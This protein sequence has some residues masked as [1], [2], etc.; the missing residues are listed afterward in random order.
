MSEEN[1]SFP[2]YAG[3]IKMEVTDEV[4]TPFGG[5]VAFA[6]FL[7]KTNILE[8]LSGHCPVARTSP[9]AA[10]IYDILVSFILTS[11]CDGDR[12]NHVN[13][14]R[15][16][17]S[18]PA[19][20][21]VQKIVGDDTIRRFFNS[22][23]R[24]KG[25]SWFA[26]NT[27]KMWSCLPKNFILDW[28]ST[29][30]TKYGSQ[31][32]AEI[33]YNPTKRGRPSFHPLLATVAGTRIVPYYL[34]RPGNTVSASQWQDAMEQCLEWLGENNRPALNRGD[35]GFGIESIMS[36]HETSLNAPK[37]LFKLKITN[38]VKA[39]IK[40]VTEEEWLGA[41]SRGLLQVVDKEIM[42]SG[43]TK[44]RRVILSRREH[45]TVTAE[46]G[47]SL[48]DFTEFKYSAYVTDLNFEEAQAWQVVDLYNQRGDC[49]NIFDELKNQWGLDGFCSR[50]ANVTELA[51]RFTLLSY[52]LWNLFSRL[53]DPD[54]HV[55]AGTGRRWYML[56]ASR[57]VKTAR[58]KIVKMSVSSAWEK[59]IKDGYTRVCEWIRS[60][61]PQLGFTNKIEVNQ[62]PNLNQILLN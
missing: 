13:R 56:I 3:N 19:L 32:E 61:A 48:F 24:E 29:V 7:K 2:T 41:K 17:P 43:W 1:F 60:T 57:L 9:N 53:M 26:L 31:E 25:R 20:F 14:L 33:G 11:L 34:M 18:L 5:L 38:K 23:E 28:D 6:S 15:Y 50:K 40:S 44:S 47:K 46:S 36:W 62:T 12:F 4:L 22:I 49:E 37:Y 59:Q 35:I 42:L 10:P 21:G 52:N 58:E 27:Q 16:D 39:L 54:K 30:L 55:E 45:R 8:N 51:A